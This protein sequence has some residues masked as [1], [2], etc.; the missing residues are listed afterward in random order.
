MLP[1]SISPGCFLKA[2]MMRPRD[3]QIDGPPGGIL[4]GNRWHSVKLVTEY[5]AAGLRVRNEGCKMPRGYTPYLLDAFS[6]DRQ[7]LD[8][9]IPALCLQCPH[10]SPV[11]QYNIWS[12]YYMP[13][14]LLGTSTHLTFPHHNCHIRVIIFISYLG[15]LR[16]RVAK[17]LL[18][19]HTAQQ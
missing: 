2:V 13:G 11:I 5:S 4:L 10:M 9:H 8:T 7:C 14:P 1:C 12:P 18:S 3:F 6:N 17:W 15:K 16:P 19:T